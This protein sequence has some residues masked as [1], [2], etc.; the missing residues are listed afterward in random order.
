MI[1]TEII[2]QCEESQMVFRKIRRNKN[3][4][5]HH[6]A[7]LVKNIDKAAKE[8]SENFGYVVKSSVIYDP[9]QTAFV[10]FLQ[11]TGN[12]A[13]LELIMPD[14]SESKLNNALKKGGGLNHF[15]YA[16]ENIDEACSSLVEKRLFLL[17]KP[18]S[19]TAFNGRRIAWLMGMDGVPVELVEAGE[20]S[21]EVD[22]E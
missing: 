18:I 22:Y 11:Q 1:L 20:D 10:Q 15:C 7:V 13:Y 21:W 8:Y 19:A 2:C 5:L 16:V 3:F 14:G 17:Q 12:A 9:I 4:V 6:T